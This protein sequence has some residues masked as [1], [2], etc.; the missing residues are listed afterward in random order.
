MHFCKNMLRC[1]KCKATQKM[2]NKRELH[3]ISEILFKVQRILEEEFRGYMKHKK[4]VILDEE[5]LR[6]FMYKFKRLK[7]VKKKN[8]KK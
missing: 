1:K 6:N 7:I 8:A 5:D 2:K 4:L 3:K